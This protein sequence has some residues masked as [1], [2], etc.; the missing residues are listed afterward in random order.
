MMKRTFAI[1]GLLWLTTAPVNAQTEEIRFDYD[2]DVAKVK[3]LLQDIR[4]D[5]AALDQIRF[6]TLESDE[7]LSSSE[8]ARFSL[9]CPILQID[10]L[11]FSDI[12]QPIFVTWDCT[13]FRLHDRTQIR[14]LRKAIFRF[15]D[16]EI[17]HVKFGIPKVFTVSPS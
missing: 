16:E 12:R 2:R 8:F 17:R 7:E 1:F 6:E 11:Y 15:E 14:S 3:T 4:E 5:T 13:D 9:E 10:A